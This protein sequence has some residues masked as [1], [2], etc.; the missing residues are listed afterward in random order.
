MP[1]RVPKLTSRSVLVVVYR[2]D[3]SI[4]GSIYISSKNRQRKKENETCW[5]SL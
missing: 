2:I 3:L 4:D 5:I 1:G